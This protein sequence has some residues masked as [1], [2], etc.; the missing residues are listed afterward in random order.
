MKKA[1]DDIKQLVFSLLPEDG[2][3]IGFNKMHKK[4]PRR[5]KSTLSLHLKRLVSEGLVVRTESGREVYYSRLTDVRHAL[6][7][8]T[9]AM[10]LLAMGELAL[11]S[12]ARKLSP[13]TKSKILA[14]AKTYA[15]L[16]LE[17]RDI[18]F[19]RIGFSRKIGPH[20]AL[21]EFISMFH[22][23]L[24]QVVTTAISDS[25]EASDLEQI[26]KR[27][28]ARLDLLVYPVVDYF[29]VVCSERKSLEIPRAAREQFREISRTLP[30]FSKGA[31]TPWSMKLGVEKISS[32]VPKKGGL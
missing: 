15:A 18:D 21:R 7:E 23:A 22:R 13:F 20:E 11:D 30:G 10:R 17:E 8:L 16:K 25:L 27:L 5:S 2:S 6:K 26:R 24:F 32:P 31:E 1:S 4:I 19:T 28:K 9:L 14:R 12:K 29:A 3:E